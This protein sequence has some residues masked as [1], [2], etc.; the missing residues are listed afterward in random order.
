MNE[1]IASLP[2]TLRQGLVVA[3]GAILAWVTNEVIPGL[4]L[5]GWQLTAVTGAWA[6]FVSYVTPLYQGM[7]IGVVDRP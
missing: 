4:D 6:W 5:S 1:I 2:G 7:G 3:I